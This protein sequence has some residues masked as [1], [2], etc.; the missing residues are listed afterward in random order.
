MIRRVLRAL[1]EAGAISLVA[2]FLLTAL[3]LVTA[4]ALA[5][6]TATPVSLLL[7]FAAK[8]CAYV[9][10]GY[11]ILRSLPGRRFQGSI[12]VVGS[13]VVVTASMWLL[14]GIIPSSVAASLMKSSCEFNLSDPIPEVPWRCG[15]A[16]FFSWLLFNI[17]GWTLPL[18]LVQLVGPQLQSATNQSGTAC[19]K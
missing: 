19:P 2:A 5:P 8:L 15:V 4:W 9:I 7:P 11:M 18:F 6:D 12:A 17:G 13:L 1:L 14:A 10:C 16:S 3:Q